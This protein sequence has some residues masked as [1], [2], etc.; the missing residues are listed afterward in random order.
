MTSGW[1][2]EAFVRFL[3][4]HRAILRHMSLLGA[5]MSIAGGYYK[6]VDA[7]ASFGMDVVQ[8]F[9]KNNN[10]WKGKPLSDDDVRLFREAIE[11]T[12]VSRPCGHTS[13]LI[14]LASGDEVLWQRSLDALVDEL[15]RA[16]RLGLEGIVM[17]PGSHGTATPEEGLAR[18]AKALDEAHK[19]TPKF[20]TQVWLEVTAGQGASLGW[21]FEHIG[22]LLEHVKKNE[23]LGVCV[24]TCHLFAAG[25][26]FNTE[27]DYKQTI[28]ELGR[29]IG[30]DRVRAFHVNDSKKPLGSRVDRHEHI[31]EGCIGIE[32]FRMLVNDKRFANTPMYLETKKEVRN[33]E[34][35]DAV[36]LRTLRGLIEK[37]AKKSAPRTRT[38]K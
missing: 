21:R 28:T 12:G 36:N 23:R 16:E 14:N 29:V 2:T 11:R 38:G 24:D 20:K 32:P 37:P 31:G 22:W 6:A 34:E 25:Y 8:L 15:D 7:A 13:Y 19:R 1:T 33:G 18:I 26:P 5:H 30:L 35:M 4:L 10:Q 27:S 3:F 17:H 9:T